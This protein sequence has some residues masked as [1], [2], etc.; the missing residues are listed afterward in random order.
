MYKSYK[1]GILYPLLRGWHFDPRDPAARQA[2]RDQAAIILFNE[3]RSGGQEK[4]A[5]FLRPFYTTG[6][7]ETTE[8]FRTSQESGGSNAPV[9]I[10]IEPVATEE[11][12]Y[13]LENTIVDALFKTLPVVALGKP[14]EAF[15]V[16][17][18]LVDEN[19]WQSAASELMSRASLIICLPSSHPGSHWEMNQI[20]QNHY[21]SKTVFIMPPDHRAAVVGGVPITRFGGWKPLH[22]DWG[23]LKQQMASD[24]ITIPPYQV[25]G[26]F[27][28]LDAKGCI[29]EKL[30]LNS[31]RKLRKIF[32][33]LSSP[34]NRARYDRRARWY[35]WAM[36]AI[37]I[38]LVVGVVVFFL[39]LH[40]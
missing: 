33:Q 40:R 14:G 31:P 27:F 15:G 12:H 38:A 6:Q 16:G 21:L 17:R 22:E 20:L 29:T 19:N 13:P 26:L 11:I 2:E 32:L 9:P 4:F 23:L 34:D 18:I 36:W 37:F 3:V 39:R 5:V 10:A 8:T 35:N 28:S 24:G 7:I 1:S 30:R 25:E